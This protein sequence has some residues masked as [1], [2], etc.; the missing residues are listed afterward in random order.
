ME[1][2]LIKS[3]SLSFESLAK[4]N[5]VNTTRT[6]GDGHP[7]NTLIRDTKKEIHDPSSQTITCQLLN[8]RP[9]PQTRQCSYI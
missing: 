7:S 6:I 9:P 1:H 5:N 8:G 3:N 2:S 4:G